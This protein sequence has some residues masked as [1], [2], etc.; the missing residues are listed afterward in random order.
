V[1]QQFT[2]IMNDFLRSRKLSPATRLVGA[3]M[4]SY[5]NAN[6][7]AWPGEEMLSKLTG[8]G[9]STIGRARTELTKGGWIEKVYIRHDDGTVK[10]VR[11][12]VTSK[13]LYGKK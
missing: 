12:E 13:L 2:Q 7:I 10:A 4:A 9:H 8:F 5:A 11:Y 1:I 6:R 3:I